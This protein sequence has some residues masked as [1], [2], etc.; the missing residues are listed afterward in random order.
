MARP[1]I[2]KINTIDSREKVDA[3]WRVTQL[4]DGVWA[5]YLDYQPLDINSADQHAVVDFF[6]RTPG[7]ACAMCPI[8][9]TKPS[10]VPALESDRSRFDM[11]NWKSL[12]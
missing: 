12:G 10:F 4:D 9:D 5:R 8:K 1:S 2:T 3:M 11:K 6:R 7:D